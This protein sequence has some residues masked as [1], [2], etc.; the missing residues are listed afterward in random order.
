MRINCAR[1]MPPPEKKRKAEA[2]SL[3]DDDNSK[4]TTSRPTKKK[5]STGSAVDSG[6]NSPVPTPS[7]IDYNPLTLPEIRQRVQTL[8]QRVPAI[9]PDGLSSTD[10]AAV[11][12]WAT[13]MQAAIEEFNLL[14]CT[15][16][17]ATYKWGAERSGASEQNLGLLSAELLNAQEQISSSVTP[18]L[19][20]VLAPVVEL[21]VKKTVHTK[22]TNADTG[23]E[24][25]VKIN[26][27]TREQNDPD[28]LKLCAEILSRNA[29]MLRQVVLANFLKADK[30]IAD[31]V[32]SVEKDRSH[33]G[34]FAY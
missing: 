12:S 25:D 31:Y 7:D 1:V 18:R 24:E 3:D 9:P 33:D 8:C 22:E 20:N 26:V 30:V 5:S 28:F 6:K 15:V 27:Y 29:A 4:S 21:V 14:I 2:A 13:S 16:S 11:R 34:R 10:A 19:T 23:K 32:K 17:A